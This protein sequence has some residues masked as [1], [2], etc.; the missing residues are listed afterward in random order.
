MGR[1]VTGAV[2]PKIVLT[3]GDHLSHC[4]NMSRTH[5]QIIALWD[6]IEAF[7]ADVGASFEAARKWRQRGIPPAH[8][9]TVLKT[10]KAKAATVTLDELAAPQPEPQSKDAA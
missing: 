10:K 7:A 9:A 8:F 5:R 2:V 3:A 6:S 1:T 4:P